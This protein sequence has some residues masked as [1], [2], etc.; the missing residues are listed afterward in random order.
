MKNFKN[1]VSS[2]SL[3][4]LY[5]ALG[6]FTAQAE[7]SYNYADS[8]QETEHRS[9]VV[10]ANT[11]G[12]H[13]T[14]SETV[15]ENLTNPTSSSDEDNSSGQWAFLKPADTRIVHALKQYLDFAVD[16]RIANRKTD[17]LFPFHDFL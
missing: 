11:L 6:S 10:K 15:V 17:L 9:S 5:F 14:E 4:L 7:V 2:V 12:L 16:L 13:S 8:S 3:L 1:I